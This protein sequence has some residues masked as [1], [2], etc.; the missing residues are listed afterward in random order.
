V[1]ATGSKLSAPEYAFANEAG[2]FQ[3]PPAACDASRA[4]RRGARESADLLQHPEL[5]EV[6]PVLGQLSCFDPNDVGARHRHLSPRRRQTLKI[7]TVRPAAGYPEHDPVTLGDQIF[8]LLAPV[9]KRP[10]NMAK[11]CLIPSRPLNSMP[12]AWYR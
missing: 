9:R 6:R 8:D 3:G 7:A 11:T 5:V 2:F 4:E 12:G 1:P 10:R